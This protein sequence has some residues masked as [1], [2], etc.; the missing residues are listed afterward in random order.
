MA[1]QIG[2]DDSQNNVFQKLTQQLYALAQ[3]I[4]E[5]REELKQSEKEEQITYD[6]LIVCFRL[7]IIMLFAFMTTNLALAL[8]FLY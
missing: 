1:S 2:N 3:H 6:W 7:D 5:W 8:W 4:R